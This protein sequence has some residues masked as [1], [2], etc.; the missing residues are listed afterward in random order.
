M[1]TPYLYSIRMRTIS[2]LFIYSFALL[3]TILFGQNSGEQSNSSEAIGEADEVYYILPDFVVTDDQDKGYYSA[4]TLAGT[5]TNELTKNI[6]MT[7]STVNEA[8]I[9]DFAMKTL[10]DLGNFVPSIEAEENV[11]NNQEIRFRGFLSRSQLYEFMPRYSPLDYYNVGRADVIRGANSLIYGQADPGGKVNIISKTAEFTKDKKSVRFETGNKNAHKFVFDMNALIGDKTAARYML[12]DKHREFDAKYKFQTFSGQT[13]ELLHNLGPKTRLRL[14]LENGEAK[15]SL[16]GGTFKVGQGPTGL[17]NGIVADPKLAD[18]IDNDFLQYLIDYT[19]ADPGFDVSGN[20]LGR[21]AENPKIWNA[22]PGGPLVPDFIRNRADIRNMFAGIDNE[23]SGTG[24]GPDSFSDRNFE[25]YIAEL[26]HTFSNDVD[27]KIAVASENLNSKSLSSGWGANQIKH[28]T[29]YGS[30]VGFPNK[31]SLEAHESD[32]YFIG[33]YNPYRATYDDLIN[34]NYANAT[35]LFFQS[36]GLN[37]DSENDGFATSLGNAILNDS[38][39]DGL[40]SYSNQISQIY[41]DQFAED[42]V[43]DSNGFSQVSDYDLAKSFARGSRSVESLLKTIPRSSDPDLNL[44]YLWNW[45]NGDNSQGTTLADAIYGI[46][47]GGNMA[48]TS[49]AIREIALMDQYIDISAFKNYVATNPATSAEFS[50]GVEE[51][52]YNSIQDWMV[53]Q[54]GGMIPMPGVD[55]ADFSDFTSPTFG[56]PNGVVD[57]DEIDAQRRAIASYV[58]GLLD[59]L[60]KDNANFWKANQDVINFF[61]YQLHSQKDYSFMWN[62]YITPDIFKNSGALTEDRTN[63]LNEINPSLSKSSIDFYEPFV[64]RTWASQT[65]SDDNKSARIT[66]SYETDAEYFLPGKQQWLL[67]IDLDKRNAAQSRYEEFQ[68]GTKVYQAEFYDGSIGDVYLRGDVASDFVSLRDLLY[69]SE[70]PSRFL[71]GRQEGHEYDYTSNSL[72]ANFKL[73]TKILNST[74]MNKIYQAETEVKTNGIWLA[75]SGTYLKGKLRSLIGLRRDTIQVDSN[76]YNYKIRALGSDASDTVVK[77]REESL[78]LPYTTPSVGGLYWM[79]KELAV[80]GNYSKSVISPTGFQY[81]VFGKLTPPETGKGYEIGFK[82]SS[83]DGK[84]NAQL[85]GFTIDKKNEQR[86]NIT[87]PQLRAVYPDKNPDGTWADGFADENG[88]VYQENDE[89]ASEARSLYDIEQK[90]E[91]DGTPLEDEN[92]FP[93]YQVIFDPLGSRVADEEARSRG[94][95]L[96]FY[97]NPTEQLSFFIGYAHLDTTILK[98][99]LS[100]L[101]GLTVPG[102]SKHNINFQ[103]R[104]KFTEGKLKGFTVGMNQKYRSAALLNNYFTDLDSDGDQDYR[105]H[106]VDGVE[107]HPVHHELY[108]ENQF[109]TDCFIKWGGKLAKGKSIPWTVFQLNVNNIFDDAQLISTGAN[110][111]RYTEG[112]TINLSAGFYF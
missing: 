27:M 32:P 43:L 111:A 58:Y 87:W 110:N 64:Q 49:T 92:G 100:A 53:T 75:A 9:E 57:S 73:S 39:F 3:Q 11:Y 24:F 38:R 99:S 88:S 2:L 8:M 80:F 89:N 41:A 62:T 26:S 14:H 10:A 13:L 68:E 47:N 104:Y 107:L 31:A 63:N 103:C 28:S 20:P 60:N 74:S 21:R 51:L 67:G 77:S 18:L 78:D 65:S 59:P 55:Q 94:I 40:V 33:S 16:I 93:I 102:T 19:N 29:R 106:I 44:G 34:A 84:I 83:Q 22:S 90:L 70:D 7:I 50:N 95:E 96:D 6:P 1:S 81:D 61:K 46:F 15:R 52:I 25:Y 82:Y 17:P 101:E 108:L 36:N 54:N 85:T 98:S 97:Y 56:Q 37:G 69:D 76:Y 105:V 4:N 66:F 45:R 72:A 35:N 42:G 23:N 86:S 112:R 30:T 48:P 12:I 91:V 71:N 109:Q 79:T 5:R